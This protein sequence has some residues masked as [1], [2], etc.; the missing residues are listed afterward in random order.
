[1][2]PLQSFLALSGHVGAANFGI[3]PGLLYS[4]LLPRP[5]LARVTTVFTSIV[6]PPFSR[7]R[8]SDARCVAPSPLS[9]SG[10]AFPCEPS[11]SR[12]R[13]RLCDSSH[14]IAIEDWFLESAN[15]WQQIK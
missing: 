5:E 6:V 11:L 7:Q 3:F 13:L 8:E 9:A 1:M 10:Y 2:N 15:S 14:L 12:R 4:V